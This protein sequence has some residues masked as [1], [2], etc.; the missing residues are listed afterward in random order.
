M[1]RI[2]HAYTRYLIDG[3]V[4]TLDDLLAAARQIA[5]AVARRLGCEDAEEIAQQASIVVWERLRQYDP[6]LASLS[7]WIGTI[8]RRLVI[9]QH[10]SAPPRSTV[11]DETRLPAPPNIESLMRLDVSHLGD[12][13]RRTLAVFA[14][15][16]DFDSAAQTLGITVLALKKRLHR[17]AARNKS[18]NLSRLAT[19]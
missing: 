12:K 1:S 17:I 9:D 3:D 18:E 4:R 16:R 19:V 11:L 7:T 8:V 15:D 2:E 6:K 5:L 13:D 10:R 14:L